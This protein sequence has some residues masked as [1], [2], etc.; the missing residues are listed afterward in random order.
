MMDIVI[1]MMLNGHLCVFF[2]AFQPKINY[3]VRLWVSSPNSTRKNI[4]TLNRDNIRPHTVIVTWRETE[5]LCWTV[6][7]QPSFSPNLL[8]IYVL[9]CSRAAERLEI[10]GNRYKIGMRR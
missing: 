7:R 3:C 1:R 4:T 2:R 5:M 10:W 6:L 9:S 8:P